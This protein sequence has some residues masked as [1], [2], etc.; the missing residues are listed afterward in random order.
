MSWPC[1]KSTE[2]VLFSFSKSV[3]S[4]TQSVQGCSGGSETEWPLG[5]TIVDKWSTWCR[6]PGELL[7]YHLLHFV[8][9]DLYRFSE[10]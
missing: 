3:D 6:V 9:L 4:F 5:L 2:F 10:N 8:V 1:F 7:D